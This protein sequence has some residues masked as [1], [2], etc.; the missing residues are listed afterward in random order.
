MVSLPSFKMV[1]YHEWYGRKY[2]LELYIS[3]SGNS[4]FSR[5]LSVNYNH[6]QGK[7][8]YFIVVQAPFLFRN[9][10]SRISTP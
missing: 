8:F 7:S 4:A 1:D 5:P 10:F 9:T 2:R 3:F 6:P